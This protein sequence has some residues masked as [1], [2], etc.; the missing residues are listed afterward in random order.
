[1]ADRP[2][3]RTDA[4]AL[5]L[6]F[7]CTYNRCRSILCEALARHL[8]DGRVAALGAGS[9]A[10][11]AVYPDT[12]L[13][14]QNFDI[15][16]LRS[17]AWNVLETLTA[18]AVVTVCDSAASRECPLWLGE[19]VKVHWGLPGPSRIQGS[20]EERAAAFNTLRRELQRFAQRSNEYGAV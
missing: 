7:V 8:S 17:D 4:P 9:Q 10:S 14:L 1:M 18:D 5:T 15:P 2:D 19:A 11:G 3:P 6:F 20:D 16:G 13:H 12:L